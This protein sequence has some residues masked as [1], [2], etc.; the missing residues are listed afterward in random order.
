MIKERLEE[1]YSQKIK[2]KLS[3][4]WDIKY[5]YWYPLY[6]CNRRDVIAF[7]S[8]YTEKSNKLE[9]IKKLLIAHGVKAIYEFRENGI[10]S[11]IKGFRNYDFWLSETYFWNNECFWFDDNMDW[12]IYVS[13][14]GTTTFGG[15]WLVEQLKELWKN[16]KSNT[17]WDTKN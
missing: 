4:E 9:L 1:E 13:H 17:S 8:E 6:D 11:Q 15:S 7:D 5:P 16:W 10:S 3:I 12:I 2:R 14:E